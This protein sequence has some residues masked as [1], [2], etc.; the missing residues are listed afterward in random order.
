MKKSGNRFKLLWVRF[1][2]DMTEFFTVW[3]ISHWDSLAK[4]I[5]ETLSLEIFKTQLD[6]VLSNHTSPLFSHR[7]LDQMIFYSPFQLWYSMIHIK[8]LYIFFLYF[9]FFKY[10]LMPFC[11]KHKQQRLKQD[12]EG[13]NQTAVRCLW[14]YPQSL[15]I[16]YQADRESARKIYDKFCCLTGN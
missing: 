4:V 5:V 10:W 8:A 13:S 16:I 9:F 1:L 7:V 3:D 6:R 11:R 2:L 12:L 14:C 15:K